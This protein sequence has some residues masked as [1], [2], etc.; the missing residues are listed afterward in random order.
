MH[1]LQRLLCLEP[2]ITYAGKRMNFLEPSL[3][4]PVQIWCLKEVTLLLEANYSTTIPKPFLSILVGEAVK[5]CIPTMKGTDDATREVPWLFRSS[6]ISE[7]H[8]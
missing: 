5:F 2:F 7:L 1:R 4:D 6:G 3:S 8:T